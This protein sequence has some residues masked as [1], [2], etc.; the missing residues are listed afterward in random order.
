MSDDRRGAGPAP[1]G[2][3]GRDA[4]DAAAGF[5]RKHL[6]DRELGDVDEAFEVGGGE[7]FEVVSRVIDERL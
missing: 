4:N 3:R 1:H 5:L 2:H 7:S 6:F